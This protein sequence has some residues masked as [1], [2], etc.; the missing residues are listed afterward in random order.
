MYFQ[1]H[2]L[3]IFQNNLQCLGCLVLY[4]FKHHIIFLFR[5]LLGYFSI[6]TFCVNSNLQYKDYG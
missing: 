6:G 1:T 2:L 5:N 4:I 3:I